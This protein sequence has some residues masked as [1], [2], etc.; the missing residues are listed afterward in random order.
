MKRIYESFSEVAEDFVDGDSVTHK[1]LPHKSDPCLSWQD[2]VKD[3]AEVLD[4]TL[5]A[6]S[7]K[8]NLIVE[9][10]LSHLAF[11]ETFWLAAREWRSLKDKEITI[12]STFSFDPYKDPPKQASIYKGYDEGD[13]P[14]EGEKPLDP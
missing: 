11:Y 8:G 5:K 6:F 14:L 2:G 13:K 7:K 3:F 12:P 4:L 10:D 9:I 1:N